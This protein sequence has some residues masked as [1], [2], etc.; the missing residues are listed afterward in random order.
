MKYLTRSDALLGAGLAVLFTI[1]AVLAV[2]L[3]G[4]E[5]K[6]NT[7]LVEYEAERRAS[8]LLESF[9]ENPSAEA[10]ELAQP[11][12]GF[13]VYTYSGAP[14][15][16]VGTA[17]SELSRAFSPPGA[18]PSGG[19]RTTGGWTLSPPGSTL[20]PRFLYDRAGRTLT[21]IRS[22]GFFPMPAPGMR[23]MGMMMNRRPEAPGLLLLELDIRNYYRAQGLYGLAGVLAPATLFLLMALFF[24]LYRRNLEY[25]R[26]MVAQERFV[27]L[28]E[29]ART[30][31]HEMKN[32]LAAIRIQLGYL[33]RVLGRR[34][35][36][37]LTVIEEEV[38]RLS[39][40]AD[41]VGDFIRHPEGSPEPL[42][43]GAF[44][45]DLVKRFDSRVRLRKRGPEALEVL[46]DR[47]R[48]RSVVE[49]LLRNALE[50]MEREGEVEVLLGQEGGKACLEVLDRGVG[51]PA[52]SLG[53]LFDPFFTTK[54]RGSGLGLAIAKAF[55]E[56]RGGRIELK[57]RAGGG[58]VV[59]VT[60]NRVF[61][62]EDTGRG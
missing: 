61:G 7:L 47:E 28:G 17:P 52:D 43:L 19:G 8:T 26:K 5:R 36:K 1:L 12:R 24:L 13:G 51:V 53:K 42:E 38:A 48:L 39:L 23:G 21:L 22:L 6:R 56:A 14:L 41:R 31:A 32:P 18:A 46:F 4:A 2:T 9:R 16:R 29:A 10:L 59:K 60:L 3:V 55:V 54:T 49:N 57:P 62:D 37:Q 44:L 30:L 58:T 15:L 34:D 50:S 20:P 35:Y 40:L 33:K 25:R 11:V 27:R 45:E